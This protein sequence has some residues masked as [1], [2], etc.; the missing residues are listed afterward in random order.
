[1]EMWTMISCTIALTGPAFLLVSLLWALIQ[2]GCGIIAA[3]FFWSFSQQI[4]NNE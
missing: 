3:Y 4:D 1:M 2:T